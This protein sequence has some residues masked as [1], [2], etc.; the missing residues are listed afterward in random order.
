MEMHLRNAKDCYCDAKDY[1][2][3]AIGHTE[4]LGLLEESEALRKRLEHVQAV[5]RSQFMQWSKI[6]RKKELKR[7]AFYSL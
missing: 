2:Y 5:F 4:E 1:F 6:R 7:F 3:A